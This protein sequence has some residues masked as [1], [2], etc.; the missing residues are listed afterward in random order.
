MKP[1]SLEVYKFLYKRTGAKSFSY[2]FSMLYL[3]AL[4][5]T[6]LY[7]IVFFLKTVFS[8]AFVKT[9]FSI[10]GCLVLGAVFFFINYRRAPY[11][12]L[13][14]EKQIEPRYAGVIMYSLLAIGILAAT[15]LLK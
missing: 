3:S 1:L 2:Y 6:V 7:G 15:H 14:K 9:A 8:D 11:D 13:G 12:I 10:P 4:N 5:L